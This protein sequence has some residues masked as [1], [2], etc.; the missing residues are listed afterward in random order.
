MVA[1]GFRTLLLIVVVG[2]TGT[3][4]IAQSNGVDGGKTSVGPQ[5]TLIASDQEAKPLPDIPALM[6]E[7]AANQR[8]EEKIS[9]D[10]LYHKVQIAR[11]SDGHGGIKK[12]ETREFDVFWVG[13][14]PVRRMTKKD[15]RE[16]SA[17][18]QKKENEEIDKAVAKAKE[19]RAKADAEGK[20]TDPRGEEEIPPSRFLE[21]GSFTN[22]RRVTLDGRDTIAVDYAGD[23]KAK[24]RNRAEEVVRDLVGTVWVDEEDRMLVKAE[25]HFVNSFKIGAGLV[26]N[27]QKG[28]SFAMQMK[29]VNGEVWLPEVMSGH[30]AMRALL[31]FSFNGD[32]KIVDSDY[33]KFKATSTIL[34]GMSVPVSQ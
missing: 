2:W 24:T 31:F 18:E 7:V 11:E 32:G 1:A 17:D 15:G 14:V 13:G 16:L 8:A 20:E 29:K 6:R 23:P 4:V 27:I 30:G 10:Y 25:G 5:Q 26:V 21:L 3:V 34:P 9:K 33:R 28:T 12:T 22:A 19:R